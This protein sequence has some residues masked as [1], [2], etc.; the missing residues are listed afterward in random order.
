MNY[1]QHWAL[2]YWIYMDRRI[3]VEDKRAELEEQTYNLF[4]E[5]WGQLFRDDMLPVLPP[6]DM[7]H[8]FAP[9]EPELPTTYDDINEWYERMEQP[10]VMTGG[11]A[12]HH[13]RPDP[14]GHAEGVGRRV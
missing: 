9:D 3:Q 13:S 12:Q 5:R 2:G 14:F 8:A 1:V 10:Q 7:G 4:P 6:G 11:A